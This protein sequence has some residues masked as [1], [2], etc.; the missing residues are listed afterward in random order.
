MNSITE[1]VKNANGRY[2]GNL[3][4]YYKL[5]MNAPNADAPYHNVRHMLH[6]LWEAY[7][8]GVHMGL[9]P[10]EL[11]IL[12]IAAIMHDY[13]HIGQKGDDSVNIERSIRALHTNCLEEDRHLIFDIENIIRATQYPYVETDPSKLT[14]SQRILRDADQS[15]TFSLVWV[16]SIVY[17][18]SKELDITPRKMLEFQVPFLQKLSFFTPWGENKFSPKISARIAEVKGMIE[19]LES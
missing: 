8:G 1:I 17:G 3:I 2:V 14:L 6:V 11:R 4:H 16:Q 19:L 13:N 9:T 18:L 15:Q 10:L 12:L 7:D 5:V